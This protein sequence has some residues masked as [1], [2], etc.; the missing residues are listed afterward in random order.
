MLNH[1]PLVELWAMLIISRLSVCEFTYSDVLVTPP[2]TTDSAVMIINRH[3]E[4]NENVE[5]LH[6]QVPS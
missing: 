2:I 5:L 6:V 4:R 1:E 3:A